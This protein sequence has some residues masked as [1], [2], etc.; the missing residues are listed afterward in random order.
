MQTTMRKV[1][2]GLA[3]FSSPIACSTEMLDYS[4]AQL[5]QIRPGFRLTS[6]QSERN[7]VC[8]ASLRDDAAIRS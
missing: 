2:L 3:T 7:T 4:S 5:S 6:F 1:T 8:I